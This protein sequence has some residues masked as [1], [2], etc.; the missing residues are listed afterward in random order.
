MNTPKTPPLEENSKPQPPDA[1]EPFGLF[2]EDLEPQADAEEEKPPE[3]NPPI[4]PRNK[5]KT[6]RA[7]DH[8]LRRF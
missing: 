6:N 2:Y 5:P 1:L 8:S 4:W 7:K 3:P